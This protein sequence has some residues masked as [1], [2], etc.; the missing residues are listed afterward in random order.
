VGHSSRVSASETAPHWI[1]P[2][3]RPALDGSTLIMF[4]SG[5]G[6]VFSHLPTVTLLVWIV[7]AMNV[8]A[9]GRCGDT[10]VV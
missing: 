8:I 9:S 10:V 4:C 6:H 2:S 3:S 5:S 1:D 7:L